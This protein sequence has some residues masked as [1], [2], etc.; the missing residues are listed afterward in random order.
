MAKNNIFMTINFSEQKIDNET[1]LE[2]RTYRKNIYD[3]IGDY[4]RYLELLL[5]DESN[6]EKKCLLEKEIKKL[7]CEQ[8]KYY[9]PCVLAMKL[10]GKNYNKE[11]GKSLIKRIFN[12]DI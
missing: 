1:W 6:Q 12:R 8:E 5:L 3:S 9:D 4:V 2:N 10:P 11:K 7:K